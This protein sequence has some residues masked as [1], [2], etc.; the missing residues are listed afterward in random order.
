MGCRVSNLAASAAGIDRQK[1]T[2]R[3]SFWPALRTSSS[4]T[5]ERLTI[6]VHK[7]QIPRVHGCLTE[8]ARMSGFLTEVTELFLINYS[9]KP[10]KI[11]IA[12]L[13]EIL[14]IILK[15]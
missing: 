7:W 6:Q 14:T 4:H 9:V 5:Q 13:S 8:S 1:E 3:V 2:C 12:W 10:K 11:K 15:T